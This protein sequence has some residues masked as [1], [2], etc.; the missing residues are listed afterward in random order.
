MSDTTLPF[1]QGAPGVAQ[2][3]VPLRLHVTSDTAT[4]AAVRRS[5]EAYARSAGFTESAIA[6]IGLVMNEALANVIRHAYQGKP[7]QPIEVEAEP[8]RQPPDSLLLRMRIRDW[9]NGKNPSESRTREYIPGEPGGLG[10]VCL[11]EMM[12]SVEYQPLP[13]GMLLTMTKRKK[14]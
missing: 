14:L 13:D 1:S 2:P 3:P 9:G 12:D 8:V 4:L 10:L 11:R 7:G 6:E 5:I